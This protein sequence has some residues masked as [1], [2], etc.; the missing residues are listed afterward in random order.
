MKNR[1]SHD[2]EDNAPSSTVGHNPEGD[3]ARKGS[4]THLHGNDTGDGYNKGSY[5]NL[6]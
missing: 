4:H 1:R 2:Y 6:A 3:R 5:P